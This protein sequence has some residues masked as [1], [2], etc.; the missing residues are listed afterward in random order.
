LARGNIRAD[1]PFIHCV[2]SLVMLKYVGFLDHTGFGGDSLDITGKHLTV[3]SHG[4]KSG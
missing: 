1:Y 2:N 4:C 3:Y